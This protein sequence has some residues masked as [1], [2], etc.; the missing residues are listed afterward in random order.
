MG[1]VLA[2]QLLMKDE[3]RSLF[4]S[5][6]HQVTF[7]EKDEQSCQNLEQHYNAPIYQGDGTNKSLLDQIGLAKMDVVIA[8]L[9]DDNQ[10]VVAAFQAKRLGAPL[11]ISLVNDPDYVPLLEENGVVAIST[12]KASAIMVENYLDRPGIA[13]LFELGRGEGSL[14]GVFVDKYAEVVG[15]SLKDIPLP[16]DCVMAAVIRE[17]KFLVPQGDTTVH[18]NDYILFVGLTSA[19]KKAREQFLVTVRRKPTQGGS[20]FQL[21]ERLRRKKTDELDHELRGIIKKRKTHE[22]DAFELLVE[23]AFVLDFPKEQRFEG[24]V[25]EVSEE[26]SKRLAISAEDLEAGFLEIKETGSIPAG[27]GVAIPHLRFSDIHKPE[28][29]LVR[30][31]A[32]HYLVDNGASESLSDQSIHAF[33]FLVS[34]DEDP[35]HHLRIL[36]RLAEV[37]WHGSLYGRV[38]DGSE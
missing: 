16:K 10:N 24:I 28:L 21:V 7:V 33:F 18:E 8:A 13:E 38:A 34:P 37:C 23:Q 22:K 11:V 12:S 2:D 31:V 6:E 14:A 15:T 30:S 4:R 3:H 9:N 19:I 1:G 36:A 27:D 5:S 35:A 17:K 29:A 32:D 25:K 26:L 20:L